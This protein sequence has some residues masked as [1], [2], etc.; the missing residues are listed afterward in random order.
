MRKKFIVTLDIKVEQVKPKL[1]LSPRLGFTYLGDVCRTV[2]GWMPMPSV[3]EHIDEIPSRAGAGVSGLPR[4]FQQ[5]KDIYHRP[6]SL[7][8]N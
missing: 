8:S 6:D 3:Q 1:M 5:Q 2:L 7:P 4:A